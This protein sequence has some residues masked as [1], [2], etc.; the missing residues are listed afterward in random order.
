MNCSSIQ[1]N[2]VDLLYGEVSASAKEAKLHLDS[3]SSCREEMSQLVEIRSIFN[4]LPDHEAPSYLMENVLALARLTPH[5]REEKGEG[6]LSRFLKPFTVLGLP[7]VP[8]TVAVGMVLALIVL[9]NS[10]RSPLNTLPQGRGGDI[11]VREGP[12]GVPGGL[13]VADE[14]AL[15]ERVLVN[16]FEIENPTFDLKYRLPNAPQGG[17]LSDFNAMTMENDESVADIEALLG[18]RRKMLV[19]ADADSLMM[20]G[21]RLKSMGRVDM[22]LKDFE[23]IYRFYPDYTYIGDVLMYRAQCYAFLGSY[24][25]ALESLKV[26]TQKFPDKAPLIGPMLEQ[27]RGEKEKEGAALNE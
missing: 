13:F 25:K 20:R 22:A 11:A 21:R 26:Y 27:L 17:T 7:Q 1:E 24:D 14:A 12:V 23:T 3:C 6:W 5:S 4:Q 15:R 16:P 8:V 18:Q 2:L 10:S 19:E 9:F